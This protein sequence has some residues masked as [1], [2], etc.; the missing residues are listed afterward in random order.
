M[1]SRNTLSRRRRRWLKR[2]HQLA[3]FVV[4]LIELLEIARWICQR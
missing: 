2:W 1:S 3:T 4:T